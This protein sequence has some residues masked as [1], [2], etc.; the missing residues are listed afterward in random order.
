VCAHTHTHTNTYTCTNT[1]SLTHTYTRSYYHLYRSYY[2]YYHHYCYYYYYYYYYYYIIKHCSIPIFYNHQLGSI[3]SQVPDLEELI[4]F[5]IRSVT[6]KLRSLI[7]L[8]ERDDTAIEF[9]SADGKSSL[10]T[11]AQVL[12]GIH[13]LGSSLS[14]QLDVSEVSIVHTHTHTHIY[15]YVL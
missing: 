2:Y 1:R 14:E 5:Q 6:E 3:F 15:I 4:R 7:T 10:I 9:P 13:V 12:R 11:T 8:G